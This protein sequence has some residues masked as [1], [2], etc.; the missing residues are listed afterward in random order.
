MMSFEQSEKSH[1][2]TPVTLMCHF[3]R[4]REILPVIPAKAGI[5]E[6]NTPGPRADLQ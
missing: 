5:Q 2:V 3:E 4:E 1:P 6:L